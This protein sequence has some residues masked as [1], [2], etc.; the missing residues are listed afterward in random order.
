LLAVFSAKDAMV[1]RDLESGRDRHFQVKGLGNPLDLRIV[2]AFAA[3]ENVLAAADPQGTIRVW[4]I[5]SG[6][7]RCVLQPEGH[8]L[9]D[10]VL[11][12]DGRTVASLVDDAKTVRRVEIW[13]IASG[14]AIHVLSTGRDY[15]G[16]L[17]FA[18]DGKTLATVGWRDVRF[19][20]VADGQECGRTKG[21]GN[22]ANG[23]AFSADGKT[24]ATTENHSGTIHLWDV[25]TGS[26]RFEPAGQTGWIDSLAFSPRGE[27]LVSG[28][29]DG[30][31]LVWDLETSKS[32]A[33]IHK[34]GWVRDC[35]FTPDGK[36]IVSCWAS[37]RIYFSDA[38]TGQDLHSVKL[39]D[40]KNGANTQDGLQM[41]VADDG[42]TL[43]VL[44]AGEN[45][46]YLLTGLDASTREPAFART[47]QRFESWGAF[48]PDLKFWAVPQDGEGSDAKK[49]I[50]RSG[51]IVLEDTATG[52]LLM[53]FPVVAGQTLRWVFRRMEDCWR[54]K[55]SRSLAKSRR[56]RFG[57]GKSRRPAKYW[58]S[59]L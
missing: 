50:G 42:K 33:G 55:R 43:V 22:F 12:P 18:P 6:A 36:S 40:P 41:R 53:S 44:S 9:R 54:P 52:A 28:G 20:K 34:V 13:D 19:W 11:S 23:I 16:K 51:P 2:S 58:P 5:G 47:R 26:L 4:D 30:T 29:M 24:L 27:R 39:E 56:G 15:P 45:G 10:M 1:L 35:E 8:Y 25:A 46:D 7:E 57:C 37:N 32:L 31:I 48:S 59:P 21:A 14:R 49:S 38:A 3:R 17:A